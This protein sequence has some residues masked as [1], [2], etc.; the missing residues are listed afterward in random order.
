M[1]KL[2]ERFR[3]WLKRSKKPIAYVAMVTFTMVDAEGNLVSQT[4]NSYVMSPS[5]FRRLSNGWTHSY[6]R[7]VLPLWDG[8]LHTFQ[9]TAIEQMTALT[10]YEEQ[11]LEDLY[12]SPRDKNN[13]MLGYTPEVK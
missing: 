7:V 10:V 6:P 3:R 5:N 4:T 11:E 2:V 12:D 13:R 8:S 9:I 1:L